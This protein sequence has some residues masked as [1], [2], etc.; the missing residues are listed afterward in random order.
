MADQTDSTGAHVGSIT[1]SSTVLYY[2]KQGLRHGRN[3]AFVRI[4]CM[5]LGTLTSSYLSCSP[6]FLQSYHFGKMLSQMVDTSLL[7]TTWGRP[8]SDGPACS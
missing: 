3:Q 1:A 6:S 2:I 8:S 7:A 4:M 5:V